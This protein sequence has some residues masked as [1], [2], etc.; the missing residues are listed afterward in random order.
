MNTALLKT[1]TLRVKGHVSWAVGDGEISYRPAVGKSGDYRWCVTYSHPVLGSL[2]RYITSDD[3][4]DVFARLRA[5][6]RVP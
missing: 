5:Q 3:A 4:R 1:A 6:R 2:W